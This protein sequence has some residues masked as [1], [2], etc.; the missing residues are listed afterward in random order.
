MAS[1]E[2][3]S[4]A[5]VAIT[6]ACVLLLSACAS[7]TSVELGGADGA[8][9]GV[10]TTAPLS[11]EEQS[12]EAE[13]LE[14]TGRATATTSATAVTE[15][16]TTLLPAAD[17]LLA[18]GV[19]PS[20]LVTT[21]RGEVVVQPTPPALQNRQLPTVSVLPPPATDEFASQVQPLEGEPLQ[22][23]TWNELCPVAPQDLRYV[24]VS[25]WGFDGGHH[26]GELIVGADEAD[27][28]VAVF[29]QLH[30]IRFPIEQMRI[31]TPSD[32]FGRPTGDGN[33]TASYVCRQ[34]T[35]GTGFSEHASGLAID[36]NPF[37]NPYQRDEV[38]IPALASSYLDRSNL[39]PGMI[40][41]GDPAGDVA[42][43]AFAAAG[44][45]WGGNWNSLKD[46]QHFALNNR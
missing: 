38:V 35:G 45:A 29:A 40:V 15:A 44:W 39:R 5:A 2:I 14:P 42:I 9:V 33:N 26:T 24:T 41:A 17:R 43:A 27:N 7:R 30:A 46:Y 18:G 32:V 19:D 8:N 31:V 23:S 37:Q 13:Q 22:R 3:N 10:A 4:R 20:T 16:S 28:I 6:I 21:P 12:E 1:I 25:F 36:I 34:V 11:G